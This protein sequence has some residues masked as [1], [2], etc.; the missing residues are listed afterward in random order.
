MTATAV[1]LARLNRPRERWCDYL[2]THGYSGMGSPPFLVEVWPFAVL[3]ATI[4]T[5]VG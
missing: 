4:V 5:L 1:S 2:L 3:P